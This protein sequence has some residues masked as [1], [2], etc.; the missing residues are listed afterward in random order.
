MGKME[1]QPT[2]MMSGYSV[3]KMIKVVP[4]QETQR[5]YQQVFL[6]ENRY[7]LTTPNFIMSCMSSIQIYF[8]I[9]VCCYKSLM[10]VRGSFLLLMLIIVHHERKEDKGENTKILGL[11]QKHQLPQH[12]CKIA[13]LPCGHAKSYIERWSPKL[14]TVV[15]FQV[16]LTPLLLFDFFFLPK[17]HC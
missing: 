5:N 13:C 2:L 4:C 10:K 1:L 15:G 7:I 12:L 6:F 16:N 17:T 8:V 9:D 3:I 11:C 14:S